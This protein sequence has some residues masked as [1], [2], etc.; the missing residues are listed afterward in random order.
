MS[1]R[2]GTWSM[3][4]RILCPQLPPRASSRALKPQCNTAAAAA[5]HRQQHRVPPPPPPCAAESIWVW[6]EWRS[7]VRHF[8]HGWMLFWGH[9]LDGIKSD[10]SENPLEWR[11]TGYERIASAE[12][13]FT[14]FACIPESA[15]GRF[16]TYSFS[17]LLPLVLS[18]SSVPAKRFQKVILIHLME[19]FL[20]NL[21]PKRF[22]DN[23]DSYKTHPLIGRLGLTGTLH[24]SMWVCL[25]KTT[26]TE[27]TV[28]TARGKEKKRF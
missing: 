2:R 12:K 14:Y 6:N 28:Q 21:D 20:E 15:G 8:D 19:R 16:C 11:Q 18:E 4:T 17:F 13:R 22:Y 1:Q 27:T 9:L 23:L 3:A 25:V 10:S 7:Q 5:V 24:V 26:V